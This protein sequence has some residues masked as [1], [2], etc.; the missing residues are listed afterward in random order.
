MDL[1]ITCLDV[2]PPD[3]ARVAVLPTSAAVWAISD[4]SEV[5]SAILP[6]NFF[7]FPKFPKKGGILSKNSDI[8]LKFIDL[9]VSTIPWISSANSLISVVCFVSYS[10]CQLVNV[11]K[12]GS[13]LS[14][15]TVFPELDI[16]YGGSIPSN[17]WIWIV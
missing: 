3:K 2:N 11:A 7:N 16:L 17:V 5:K 1:S 6:T 12:T 4:T 14:S 9:K 13:P 15:K 10:N 8:A